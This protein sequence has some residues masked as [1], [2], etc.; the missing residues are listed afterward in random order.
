[1]SALPKEAEAPIQ[2]LP[3]PERIN[4]LASKA[5]HL[6]ATVQADI[7]AALAYF[8]VL[9]LEQ[10]MKAAKRLQDFAK[11]RRAGVETAKK[12]AREMR[13]D[14]CS[15]LTET[16]AE[17]NSRNKHLSRKLLIEELRRYCLTRR[18]L[19]KNG[20]QIKR[21][22]LTRWLTLEFEQDIRSAALARSRR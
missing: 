11:G 5:G 8:A 9:D 20:G 12:N 3:M 14:W 19:G 16:L 1:M 21:Q 7:N 10:E 2:D 22:T 13:E 15:F 4:R 6:G 17:A 18:Y